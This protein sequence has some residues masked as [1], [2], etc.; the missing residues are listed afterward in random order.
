MKP[1]RVILI[2][3]AKEAYQKLNF[4]VGKQ[5]ELGKEHTE[6]MQLLKSIKQK[7]EFIK[8]NPFYGDN[9]KKDM[10]PKEYNVSNLL[11][12][13]LSQFWR[14]LYTIKGDQVEIICFI[15]DIIDHP[16]YDKKFGYRK[17]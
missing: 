2:N 14:M 7:I 1:V 8:L 3:E 15:L 12:V 13:E 5:I 17:K 11:R 6:E 4:I 16:T 9:I 10:I